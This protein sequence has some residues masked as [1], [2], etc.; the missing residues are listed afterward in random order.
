MAPPNAARE[1]LVTVSG[2]EGYWARKQGGATASDASK[3]W[4]GGSLRPTVLTAP[5]TTEDVTVTR[6]FRVERDAPLLAA[7][8]R[9][10]G[11][12][13]HTITIT[14][15]DR[16]LVPSGQPENYVGVLRSVSGPDTDAGSGDGANIELVFAI[17]DAS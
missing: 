10:V 11:R 9:V 14:P 17:E 7:L 13:S 2:I 4:D 12:S 8:K 6:P 1:F 16:D 5:A 15:T 3:V